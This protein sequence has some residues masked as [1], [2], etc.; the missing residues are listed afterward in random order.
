[1]RFADLLRIAFSALYQQKVRT[2]LTLLGVVIGTLT[3]SVSLSLG[4]GF[5]EAMLGQLTYGN[6]L[7]QVRVWPSFTAEKEN[8]SDEELN[9]QGAMSEAKRSRLRK[10]LQRHWSL[11]Q[12]IQRRPV[13]LTPEKVK[14]IEQIPHVQFVTPIIFD[15]GWIG[16]EDQRPAELVTYGSVHDADLLRKLLV[17]GE[18]RP[19]T[20]RGVVV[21]EYLLYLWGYIS[22]QQVHEALGKRIRLEYRAGRSKPRTPLELLLMSRSRLTDEESSV[23]VRT[24]EQ[25]ATRVDQVYP[26]AV[27]GMVGHAGTIP[28][29]GSVSI[30]SFLLGGTSL[31]NLSLGAAELHVLQKMFARLPAG[32]NDDER[33]LFSEEFV[34]TGVMRE[35]LDEDDILGWGLHIANGHVD[36]YL[37]QATAEDLYFRTHSATESG[38]PV[39]IVQVDDERHLR[40]VSRQIRKMKLMEF[41]LADFVE[42]VRTGIFLVIFVTTLLALVALLVA[43]LGIINTM[44]ISVLERTH[45]IGVMKAVG[46]RDLHIQ[47]IFLV[48]GALLGLIGGCLG[49]LSCWLASFPGESVARTLLE[50]QT[51]VELKGTLFIFPLWL[52]LGIPA[53]STLVTTLAAVVPARRAARIDPITALRHE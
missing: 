27:L 32:T 11:T 40:D 29:L 13:Q 47:T 2:L 1:L 9:I 38:Y 21:H 12:Q 34:I 39:A 16:L 44:I 53:F 8:T 19:T 30:P 24:F 14:A 6:Q 36:V 26:G 51:P 37:N 5:Q 15:Y 31:E 4:W 49:L 52:V 25:L 3:L 33:I 35:L 50:K 45:E 10:A 18:Y 28:L 20:G 17:A 46:A 22:D 23:L 7:Q 43:A 42:Q 48:E 41:S